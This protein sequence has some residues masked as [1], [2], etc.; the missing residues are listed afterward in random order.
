MNAALY[1]T[2]LS[3]N[4]TRQDLPGKGGSC[5]AAR[6]GA[7]PHEPA[8]P[9]KLLASPNWHAF[10]EEAFGN[11]RPNK[12]SIVSTVQVGFSPAAPGNSVIS[13]IATG[14]TAAATGDAEGGLGFVDALLAALAPD[15]ALPKVDGATNPATPVAPAPQFMQLVPVEPAAD[16]PAN[17]APP[18]E[19]VLL[20]EL[21]AL[22]G[23]LVDAL[24]ALDTG[25]PDQPIDPALEDKLDEMVEALAE[26]LGI[27]L[28]SPPAID[29]AITRA[30]AGFAST[31]AIDGDLV[32]SVEPLP[33]AQ[34]PAQLGTAP[35]PADTP[36]PAR[37]LL[38]ALGAVLPATGADERG[39]TDATDAAA[40]I[41]T[42]AGPD[43][44]VPPI[45]VDPRLVR[46]VEKLER[47]ADRL[48]TVA[49]GLAR[50]LEALS[51]L[52]GAPASD[53]EA[54][55]SQLAPALDEAGLDTRLAPR[56]ET[57]PATAPQ[58]FA[59]PVL[60][61]PIGA[62]KAGEPTTAVPAP[63]TPSADAPSEV[64]QSEPATP[65]PKQAVE[66]T[67]KQPVDESAPRDRA[68][69]AQHLADARTDKPVSGDNQTAPPQAVPGQRADVALAPRAVHA[70]YQAPLQQIN[71]GQVA[72]EVVRQVHQG[73]NRFQI[74][75]DPPELGRIDV[76]LQIDGDGNTQ[77][78]MT[79][80]R[81][82]TLDLMQRD[83]RHLEKA[84]A[85]AG[86]D[87]SKTTLEFSLRQN[88]NGRDG[89]QQQFQNQQQGGQGHPWN[90][91]GSA[92]GEASADL[93]PV[94]QSY[95]GSLT[96]SGVNLFV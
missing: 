60:P 96:Q 19:P 51:A 74:R 27:P 61:N 49:P 91:A 2:R 66:T 93:E 87:A 8:N 39:Q 44:E 56:S 53:S 10:C 69:F 59:P 46:L 89:F 95:R 21:N 17:D 29:P 75:L 34:P 42:P 13:G 5:R 14:A 83:Q 57:K 35:Q 86:L 40:P 31:A 67:T 54:L 36:D 33:S 90:R 25:D 15:L 79:V 18:G 24:A 22:L 6:S 30:A 63:A 23:D 72:F 76:R 81:A 88:P 78:R 50:K 77:A 92:H 84:L 12:A 3:G 4:R 62:I 7:P 71:L 55:M 38:A 82:E 41:A 32:P 26:V 47:V 11:I 68:G 16:I 9:L 65:Q 1:R 94:T 28:P 70:A 73:N 58:P 52:L 43:A 37:E 45:P 85:Q 20:T 48:D 64:A 80:E